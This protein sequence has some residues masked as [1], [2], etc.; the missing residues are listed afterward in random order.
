MPKVAK[1]CHKKFVDARKTFN[2]WAS[3]GLPQNPQVYS[4]QIRDA[5]ED[6]GIQSG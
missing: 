6:P 4:L 5:E 2:Y 3:R 1:V